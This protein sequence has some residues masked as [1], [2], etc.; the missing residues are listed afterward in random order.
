MYT[1]DEQGTGVITARPYGGKDP[2]F[3]LIRRRTKIH[4]ES[5]HIILHALLVSSCNVVHPQTVS[6]PDCNRRGGRPVKLL[7]PVLPNRHN[8]GYYADER[9]A[10]CFDIHLRVMYDEVPT[11]C[12]SHPISDGSETHVC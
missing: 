3:S 12:I 8:G 4:D 6:P 2:G 7:R 1:I 9:S 10:V 5:M 11:G